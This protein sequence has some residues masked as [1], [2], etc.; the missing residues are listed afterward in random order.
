MYKNF[1]AWGDGVFLG[2]QTVAIAVLVM[3]YNGE[4]TKA[5]AF[6]SAYLA[7]IFAA[8]SGLTPIHVLWTCQAMNIPI[9]LV[10]KVSNLIYIYTCMCVCAHI[11]IYIYIC[12]IT[13]Y[14]SLYELFQWKYWPVIGN[15]VLLALLRIS[16]ENLYFHSGDR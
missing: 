12:M 10:S 7:V 5:T 15:N 8:N 6:L 11:D 2:F 9:I 14:T 3:H 13:V 16:C 1:S 4:T